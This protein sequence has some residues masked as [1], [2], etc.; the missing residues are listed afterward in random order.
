[1]AA[2]V[3]N[4][5]EF[6]KE[7]LTKEHDL[8]NDTLQCALMG[9][10]FS[11]DEA[12]HSEWSDVSGSE[13][14]GGSGYT[15]GGQTLTNVAVSIN[16]TDGRVEVDADNPSWTASGGAIPTVGGAVIYNSSH[17]SNTIFCELV[18]SADYDT[19]DGK[20]L[21][22]DVSNGVRYFDNA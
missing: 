4:S 11:A 7:M 14:A 9:S 10:G 6:L 19:P 22:I 18:F 13:I 17:A 21:Q 5:L 20:V 12:S 8:E 1:M 2:T 16:S 15:A 3:T